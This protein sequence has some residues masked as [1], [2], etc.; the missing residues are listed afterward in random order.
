MSEE[1]CA[2]G[3][4]WSRSYNPDKLAI[5]HKNEIAK[6]FSGTKP[7]SRK[8]FKKAVSENIASFL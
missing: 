2:N 6:D 8:K 5:I 4:A 7:L 1:I 3:K